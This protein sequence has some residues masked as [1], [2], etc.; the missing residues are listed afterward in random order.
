[1]ATKK[2]KLL[3]AAGIIL[4]LLLVGLTVLLISEKKTNSELIQ[5]FELEK[6]DLEN[7]YSSFAKQYDEL[8]MTISNDSLA[9]L[10]EKE[11]IKTHR[12]LEELKTV[13]SSN[14]LEIRRLKNELSTLRKVMVSYI[15]QIDSLNKV[16]QQQR[17]VIDEVTKKYN[18]A[19][20]QINTLAQ[21]KKQLNQKVSLAAQLDVTNIWMKARNKRDRDA[22]KL[23]DAVKFQIGFTIVKNITAQT[24]DRTLFIR[25]TK[26]DQS[27]L[28]KDANL[29]FKYENRE[30]PFSIK[31]YIE[32]DGEEQGIVVYWDI[33]EF[34]YAGT[35]RVDV[36][37]D[38]T[39]IGSQSFNFDK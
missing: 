27:V 5:G 23:K 32:Y 24:G 36:F 26:P 38:A 30:L 14:A 12:L 25:I 31:K 29:T 2:N 33:E 9:Q 28:T 8:Q 11:Q 10:L 6:E 37:A 3:I 18:T 39:L 16:T 17:I 7:E 35:Y 1:M 13:K 22:K 15:N 19:S 21:E 20:R 4:V 34:L